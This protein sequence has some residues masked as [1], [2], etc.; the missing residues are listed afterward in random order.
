MDTFDEKFIWNLHLLRDVP[1]AMMPW[2]I[3]IIQGF[4]EQRRIVVGFS[5]VVSIALLARRSRHF[6]GTR[7]NKRGQDMCVPPP[8][9]L[10]F[11]N[12]FL[13]HCDFVT[14]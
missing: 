8:P 10:C 7:Y 12:N 3:F 11:C 6:A 9:A 5:R 14:I 1:Q 4:V 2:C 13:P